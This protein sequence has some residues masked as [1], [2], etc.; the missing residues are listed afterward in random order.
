MTVDC[1]AY[2]CCCYY[3]DVLIVRY[4]PISFPSVVDSCLFA[5]RLA[6]WVLVSLIF[7]DGVRL[8]GVGDTPC[9]ISCSTISDYELGVLLGADVSTGMV[10]YLIGIYLTGLDIIKG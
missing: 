5:L 8:R 9:V 1:L 3:A 10:K 6:I 7:L 2:E 4:G